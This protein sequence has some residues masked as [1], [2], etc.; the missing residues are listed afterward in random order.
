[1][2]VGS[3]DSNVSSLLFFFSIELHRPLAPFDL[4][5]FRFTDTT[6]GSA[7]VGSNRAERHEDP[8]GTDTGLLLE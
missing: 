2:A 1:M 6:V 4:I 3:W 5:P 8:P 7:A